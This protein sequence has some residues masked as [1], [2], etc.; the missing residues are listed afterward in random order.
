MT[1][2][3][4]VVCRDDAGDALPLS[5]F[6]VGHQAPLR[7][8]GR[9]AT[10][11]RA[12]KRLTWDGDPWPA[13]EVNEAQACEA[14][15]DDIDDCPSDL[16]HRIGVGLDAPE[17]GVDEHGTRFGEQLIVSAYGSAGIFE[18]EV[19]VGPAA[20]HLFAAQQPSGNDEITLFFVARDDRGGVDW[21][22]RTV[23]VR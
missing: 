10:R 18:D 11:T 8:R 21:A 22:V 1:A 12:S 9:I 13:D 3:V 7:A 17:A 15:G 2:G 20:D 4:P 5:E 14:Q 19:R 6:E 16:R 23:R